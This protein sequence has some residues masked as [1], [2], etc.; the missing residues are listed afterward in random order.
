MNMLSLVPFR[1][2]VCQALEHLE[3]EVA[4]DNIYFDVESKDHVRVVHLCGDVAIVSPVTEDT[5]WSVPLTNLRYVHHL[6]FVYPERC[7]KPAGRAVGRKLWR[8]FD[9]ANALLELCGNNE[10]MVHVVFREI[11]KATVLEILQRRAQHVRFPLYLRVAEANWGSPEKISPFVRVSTTFAKI[12]YGP[13]AGFGVYPAF[14]FEPPNEKDCDF[15]RVIFYLTAIAA[16]KQHDYR[17]L[18]STKDFKAGEPLFAIGDPKLNDVKSHARLTN[19]YIQK[20]ENLT[21]CVQRYYD[22]RTPLAFIF[23]H[24]DASQKDVDNTKEIVANFTPERLKQTGDG[25]TVDVLTS[26]GVFVP[27]PCSWLGV[28]GTTPCYSPGFGAVMDWIGILIEKL[29]PSHRNCALVMAYKIGALFGNRVLIHKLAAKC[30]LPDESFFAHTRKTAKDAKLTAF[31]CYRAAI[32]DRL[33]R[34]GARHSINLIFVA[35]CPAV[36]GGRVRRAL[37]AQQ[38]L[39]GLSERRL[40][41][42]FAA[43]VEVGFD[44]KS[45]PAEITRPNG[46]RAAELFKPGTWY[47]DVLHA[48]A[49]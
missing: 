10:S 43:L 39:L 29:P 20:V 9:A 40:V 32:F 6:S 44:T 22:G 28:F 11:A 30:G 13:S 33:G 12:I 21:S 45:A 38:T 27:T 5:S 15:K 34:S 42:G 36:F 41:V 17:A 2:V 47:S 37:K 49:T 4:V 1:N 25:P 48:A 14:W 18:L 24:K 23:C 8:E 35:S 7:Q 46:Q 26:G 31:V 19:K 16:A 3:L